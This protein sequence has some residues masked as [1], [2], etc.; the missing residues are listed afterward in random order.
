MKA[1]EKDDLAAARLL[2]EAGADP[3]RQNQ[4]AWTALSYAKTDQMRKL[5][6]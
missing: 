5:L 6:G 1:A 2:L 3:M 4:K